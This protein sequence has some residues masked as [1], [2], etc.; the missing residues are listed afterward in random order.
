[1]RKTQTK[2]KVGRLFGFFATL[3]LAL[4]VGVVLSPEKTL[5]TQAATT[6]GT[7][8]K[9]ITS[10]ANLTTGK[11]VFMGGENTKFVMAATRAVG[12]F[13]DKFEL[14]VAGTATDLSTNTIDDQNLVWELKNSGTNQF[15]INS[16]KD[17][18][19]GYL[20]WSSGNA[21]DYGTTVQ[22]WTFSVASNLFTIT[23]VDTPARIFQYNSSSPRFAAYGNAGQ[24]KIGLY[25]LDESAAVSDVSVTPSSASIEV[26]KT[27]Q[28]NAMVSPT[29]A[30][31]GVFWSTDA[32]TVA[33]VDLLG[34]VTG[35]GVGTATITATSESD[36]TKKDSATITVSAAAILQSIYVTGTPTKLTYFAGQDFDPDGITV[37]AKYDKGDDVDVTDEATYSP[38]P[39]TLGL[40]SVTVTF[41]GKTTSVSGL[42]VT[43]PEYYEAGNNFNS[44]AN[45][46]TS[47]IIDDNWNWR[48]IKNDASTDTRT[49]TQ[50]LRIYSKGEFVVE[51][52]TINT[53]ARIISIE[54][55][56]L[57][58]FSYS[59]FV[60]SSMNDLESVKTIKPTAGSTEIYED[61]SGFRYASIRNT[62]GTF[63][64]DNLK[65]KYKEFAV[66]YDDVVSLDSNFTKENIKVG[67]SVSISPTISPA[68]ASQGFSLS[69]ESD[70]IQI[71]GSLI[72]GVA[73]AS[74]VS[75]EIKTVG[76]NASG[77]QLTKTITFDVVLQTTTVAEA[78]NLPVGDTVYLVE[79][80]KVSDGYNTTNKN[81]IQLEDSVD[82]N[83]TILLFQYDIQPL[84]SYNYIAGGTI[85]FKAKIGTYSSK[86]QFIVP[87]IVSYTDRV[88][89]F[90]ASINEGDVEGQCLTRFAGY[91]TLVLS[92]TDIELDKFE[93]SANAAI[94]S[95]R[96]RYL[97]WALHMGEKPFEI[98]TISQGYT[99]TPTN[100]NI[101][102][103]V[104]ISV[105][106]LTTLAG[107]YFFRKKKEA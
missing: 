40:T 70:K 17:G 33:T 36:S 20:S 85:T 28:L 45:E 5:E 25:K 27:T 16:F 11:Y 67:E 59:L 53:D 64:I 1:M 79:N 72:K 3:V 4:G 13:Q 106:G 90:A 91:K 38:S 35:V 57:N 37:Y 54:F 76:K 63:Q 92:F 77:N 96:A 55:D 24:T 104:I 102:A 19:N 8:W 98:G 78:L 83:K 97:A 73:E 39:L 86:N 2:R 18:T 34:K 41:N 50:H 93:L 66:S 31:S 71:I 74:D 89:E 30:P 62:D 7:Q 46:V 6:N 99:T 56:A 65:I 80:A 82:P 14:T 60:G 10:L 42:T 107:Y 75:V 23:N 12:S 26:G 61:A 51:P 22:S 69:T 43:P 87:T 95:A 44:Y 68:T 88:E 32:P 21:I 49:W 81:Q 29:N 15:T 103:I 58:S 48:G 84:D 47:G 9:R 101:A 94:V 52:S 105:L 100:N